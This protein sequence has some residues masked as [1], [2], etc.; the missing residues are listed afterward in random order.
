MYLKDKEKRNNLFLKITPIHLIFLLGGAGVS[1]LASLW[2]YHW[3]VY[4]GRA[5]SPLEGVVLVTALVVG[6]HFLHVAFKSIM[7]GVS[8]S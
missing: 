8:G 7:R 2:V 5:V 3:A 4:E 1:A 6:L